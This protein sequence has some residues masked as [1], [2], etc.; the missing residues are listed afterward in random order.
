VKECRSVHAKQ[1]TI[2]LKDH[3][4]QQ[5]IQTYVLQDII[6]QNSSIPIMHINVQQA[7]FVQQE[8]RQVKVILSTAIL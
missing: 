1:A 6:A 5:A 2:A 7:S 3:R 4:N 8:A